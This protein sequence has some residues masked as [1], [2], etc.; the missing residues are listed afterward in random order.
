LILLTEM[1]G[2]ADHYPH[3]PT[4]KFMFPPTVK[5]FSVVLLRR[6]LCSRWSQW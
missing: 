5:N 2:L 1:K 6:S 4:F 3:C